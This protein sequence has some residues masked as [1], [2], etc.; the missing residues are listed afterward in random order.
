MGINVTLGVAGE[1]GYRTGKG[2]PFAV[3][4]GNWSGK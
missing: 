4:F 1:G 2:I 3:P